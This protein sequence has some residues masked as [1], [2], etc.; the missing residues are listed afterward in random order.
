MQTEPREN[1][2]AFQLTLLAQRVLLG[3]VM[4]PHGAQK[5]LG[6][7]GGYGFS[8]TMGF[9]TG[10]LHLPAPLALLVILGESLGA[11]ALIAG[12]GTRLAAFGISAIMVG[13]VLTT[14]AQFGFFMNWFG[15]QK[16]EGFEYHLLVLALSLPLVVWGGGRFAVDALVR[17]RRSKP[18]VAPSAA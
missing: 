17:S 2:E 12:A 4:F 1:P 14:H 15:A 18:V 16:G 3:L 11:L 5:L 7:F 13:A 9:F 6:W 8:G 10:T